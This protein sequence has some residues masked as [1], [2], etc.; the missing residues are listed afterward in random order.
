MSRSAIMRRIH[1]AVASQ[2]DTGLARLRRRDFL[3]AGGAAV[4][5]AA[6]PARAS[7]AADERIAIVGGGI[8]GLVAALALSDAGRACT[9]FESSDRVGGRMHSNRGY[10]AQGQTS[11]WCGEFID[12]EHLVLRDLARRFGLQLDDVNAADPPGSV[13]TNLLLGSY[14][15]GAELLKD[16]IPVT[17]A[18]APQI[19]AVGNHYYWND[20][21]EAAIRFDRMTCF[22]WIEAYVPGG[23]AS[24]LGLYIDLGMVSLNGLDTPQQSALNIIIPLSSDERFHVRGGNQRIP[25]AVA[26]ALPAGTL[27]LGWRLQAV[28]ANADDGVTLAFDAPGGARALRFDRVILALPFSV[29]RR[30]DTSRAGFDARKQAMIERF[31]YGTNSKLALQFDRRYWNGTGAWPGVSDGFITTDIGFQGTWDT[32]RAQ[33]GRDGL[34]TNYTG[35]TAGAAYRPD[36]PYTDSQ[37]SPATA[38]Y[39]AAFLQQLEEV[40]PGITPC[41]TGRATL[42]YPT[43]DPNIGASYSAFGVGQYTAFCGYGAVPQGR[44]HFAGEHT[45]VRF[46]GYMEGGAETGLR[47]AREVLAAPLG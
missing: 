14:Y 29:L 38:A 26:S 37:A 44:I 10:W 11:E 31:G 40:W 27:R 45:S 47:A 15:T 18:L 25:E 34:L 28:I 1:Q 16:L 43:G 12:S 32:S 21:N 4:A 20:H 41:Y 46:L 42:S 39:A 7:G 6:L 33:P 13:D 5:T 8:A 9:V 2:L 3:L 23:H 19:A 30:I 17:R 24:R 22:D 35:G 36:G